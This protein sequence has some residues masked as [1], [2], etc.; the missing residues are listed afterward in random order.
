MHVPMVIAPLM[1]VSSY[2]KLFLPLPFSFASKA[3]VERNLS[4]STILGFHMTSR[5]PCWCPDPILW[6]IE[7]YYLIH[8]RFFFV[9]I[10][11]KWLLITWLKTKNSY[12]FTIAH[13]ILFTSA[14]SISPGSV[15][16]SNKY[17][18]VSDTSRVGYSK[19]II[20]HEAVILL[21]L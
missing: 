12:H 17:K 11:K 3:T 2:V 5:P 16:P 8:K 1:M 9:S 21:H 6:E 13:I 10:E 19:D 7:L 4:L 14:F 18:I 15:V 20:I